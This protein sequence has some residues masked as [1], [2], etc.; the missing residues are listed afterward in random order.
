VLEMLA[1]TVSMRETILEVRVLRRKSLRLRKAPLHTNHYRECRRLM[2]LVPASWFPRAPGQSL[3]RKRMRGPAQLTVGGALHWFPMEALPLVPTSRFPGVS[4][5]TP[6]LLR[7]APSQEF[8]ERV[9][10]TESRRMMSLRSWSPKAKFWSLRAEVRVL[11]SLR[12]W[13]RRH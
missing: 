1:K 6:A 13:R 4:G 5:R 3:I 9:C 8:W 10:V 12:S 11:Q 2:V 7:R